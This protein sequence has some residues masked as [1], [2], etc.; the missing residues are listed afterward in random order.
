QKSAKLIEK[1]IVSAEKKNIS[2]HAITGWPEVMT[3]KNNEK[4]IK[5]LKS[6]IIFNSE[7][8]GKAE[9]KSI[10]LNP[11]IK[12]QKTLPNLT[13]LNKR[14][15]EKINASK[16][17]KLALGV[18]IPVPM[19]KYFSMDSSLDYCVIEEV[20][21]YAPGI[22]DNTASF[23]DKNRKVL[24]EIETNQFYGRQR[25]LS[26]Y[27][28]GLNEMEKELTTVAQYY[29]KN[30]EFKGFIISDYETFSKLPN[31]TNLS[32]KYPLLTINTQKMLFP[33]KIDGI[34]NEW[35][36]VH[37]VNIYKPEQIINGWKNWH[38]ERDCSMLYRVAWDKKNL[39][40]YFNITDEDLVFENKQNNFKGDSIM[41]NIAL[42][43]LDQLL[44][45]TIKPSE[46]QDK[47]YGSIVSISSSGKSIV[48]IPEMI[49]M[50]TDT[51]YCIECKIPFKT[52]Q[53]LSP[54]TKFHT[55]IT[56]TDKDTGEEESTVFSDAPLSNPLRK[57][58]FNN[59]I[60]LPVF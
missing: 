26:F 29:N 28:E 45:L 51:G 37:P 4:I 14:M 31:K 39:Y 46:K 15:K 9:F 35:I 12:E 44:N 48:G 17:S 47:R 27:E 56:L 60:L 1:F 19:S 20:S 32:E 42:E 11:Y 6:I 36:D 55:I 24:L 8:S 34:D 53:N 50:Q 2:I 13:I 57:E 40:Y 52:S 3:K 23:V 10:L 38:G 16:N 54:A 30:K 22:I 59:L 18:I 58:T 5:I 21:D 7:N 25:N 49:T 43:N 41:L 33:L